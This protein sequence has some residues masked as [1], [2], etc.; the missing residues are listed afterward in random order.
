MKK[1]VTGYFDKAVTKK[2]E[3]DKKKIEQKAKGEGPKESPTLIV[4]AAI[5]KEEESEG[6]E[7]VDVSDV[8]DVREEQKSITPITPLDQI[9]NGDGLKRKREP[10][11]CP[12]GVQLEELE[13]T[14]SK[15]ARS[16]TPPMPPS[17]PP[18]SAASLEYNAFM[19]GLNTSER[20]GEVAHGTLNSA[21]FDDPNVVNGEQMDITEQPPPPPPPPP[22]IDI[23][24][25]M[26][27]NG[28]SPPTK[29]LK[30]RVYNGPTIAGDFEDSLSDE[31]DE[32]LHVQDQSQGRILE[33]HHGI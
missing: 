24:A 10:D 31:R 18:L 25:K 20:G 9:V 7:I 16:V 22:P 2:Q 1:Y 6:D 3:H 5:K 11:E 15:K 23:S 26:S 27:S 32:S 33:V 8:D 4:E 29:D 12:N 28:Y 13:S 30:L 14:P 17:P 19:E 21:S